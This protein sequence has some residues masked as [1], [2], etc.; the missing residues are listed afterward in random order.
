[1]LA[2]SSAE[3][4]RMLARARASNIFF[5]SAL[6]AWSC[7]LSHPA[8]RV[9]DSA[10]RG[11]FKHLPADP[12]L[13]SSFFQQIFGCLNSPF[14]TSFHVLSSKLLLLPPLLLITDNKEN[15]IFLIYKEIQQGSVG[16]SYMTNRSP[17]I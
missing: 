7:W 4:C 17:H 8:L 2:D 9:R 14:G 13:F 6:A 1:L 12:Y 10:N 15:Q 5:F 11:L 16:K 3:L